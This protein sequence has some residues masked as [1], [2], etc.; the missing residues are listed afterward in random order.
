M[1]RFAMQRIQQLRDEDRDA[2]KEN[3]FTIGKDDFV[4]FMTQ[5]LGPLP[6]VDLLLETPDFAKSGISYEAYKVYVLF[7]VTS[8]SSSHDLL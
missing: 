4:T 7:D 8:R 6:A 2:D 1:W 5:R 3:Q